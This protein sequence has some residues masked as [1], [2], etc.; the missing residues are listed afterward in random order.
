MDI[1]KRQIYSRA[2]PS[3]IAIPSTVIEINVIAI[4]KVPVCWESEE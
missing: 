4:R 3:N 2:K 1:P